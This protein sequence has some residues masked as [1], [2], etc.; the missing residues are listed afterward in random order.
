MVKTLLSKA[1]RSKFEKEKLLKFAKKGIQMKEDRKG[2]SSQSLYGSLLES[3]AEY[4]S[5]D[6]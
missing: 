1:D 6:V 5:E 3:S 4:L 2:K